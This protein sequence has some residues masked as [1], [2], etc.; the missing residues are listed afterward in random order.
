MT[1]EVSLLYHHNEYDA[2]EAV[3]GSYY[4]AYRDG[5][6]TPVLAPTLLLL[7]EDFKFLQ[8]GLREGS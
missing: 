5:F 1:F 6:S 7:E 3:S 4:C 8:I 2:N